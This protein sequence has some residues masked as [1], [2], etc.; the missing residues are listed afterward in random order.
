M[1]IVCSILSLLLVTLSGY[2]INTFPYQDPDAYLFGSLFLM[3]VGGLMS[4]LA[5]YFSPFLHSVLICTDGCLF[6]QTLLPRKVVRWEQIASIRLGKG[7]ACIVCNNGTSMKLRRSWANSSTVQ[8][9]IYGKTFRYL[10]SRARTSY[11]SGDAVT[12]G[13][14]TVS[15]EGIN[16]G[17]QLFQ[18]E[19]LRTC[20][21]VDSGLALI[22]VEDTCLDLTYLSQLPDATIFVELIKYVLA[23]RRMGSQNEP[24]S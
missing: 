22:S 7:F 1:N 21:Y 24:V 18:W 9:L 17:Q 12:F 13:R 2:F 3:V 20:V 19:Q 10:F 15:W 4:S 16:N 6:M 11:N 5:L 23:L 14:F 8:H